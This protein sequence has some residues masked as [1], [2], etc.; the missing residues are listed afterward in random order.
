[1]QKIRDIS[2]PGWFTSILLLIVGFATFGLLAPQLGF[3]WDDWSKTLVNILYGFEGYLDYYAGD[4]PLS[5][6]THVLFVSLIGNNQLYWQIL[7]T[8]LRILSAIGLWWSFKA[9]WPA[10]QRDISLAATL[11]LVLPIF[12][13]QAAAVTF[14]QQWLQAACYFFALGLLIRSLKSKKWWVLL[15]IFS[16]LLNALQLT[17]TEYYFGL[18]LILPLFVGLHFRNQNLEGWSFW[19]N[20]FLHS[21]PYF[22]LSIIYALWRFVWMKLPE[23]DPY[24]MVTLKQ[25]GSQPLQ[26]TLALVKIIA[27]DLLEVI[28][29]SWAPVF[30]LSLSTANQ[31]FTLIS[32]TLSFFVAVSV[33]LFF[34]TQKET[35]E[36]QPEKVQPHWISQ[37][38]L[39]SFA[40]IF[41]GILPAWA[42]G[43]NVVL[44]MH[45]NRY[46]M[47]AMAGIALLVVAVIS[48][49]IQDWQRKVVA[50]SVLIGLASGFHLREM[51]DYRWNWKKQTDF[52]WQ[53]YWRAPKIQEKTAIFFVEEPFPP[54]GLFSTSSAINLLYGTN[55][56]STDLPYWAYAILPRYAQAEEFPA[57]HVIHTTFRSLHFEGNVKNMVLMH[58]NPSHQTCWWLLSAGDQLNPYLSPHEREWA[59]A[60]N[61]D[62]ISDNTSAPLPD[63]ELFGE[64]PTHG[65]CYFYEK[66][67]L[68]VQKEDWAKVADVGDQVQ[69]LGYQ[70]EQSASSNSPREWLPFIL[71]YGMINDLDKAF[72]L[73][74]KSYSVD[75]NYQPMLC[76]VWDEILPVEEED[77]WRAQINHALNCEAAWN[78][79][80]LTLK[81]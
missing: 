69:E 53:L 21:L 78:S 2:L 80:K 41:A 46:A 48:W 23:A 38:K 30:G 37:F 11:Y 60:S 19:K 42:I 14:H 25:L 12:T 39:I 45:A 17:V 50:L 32:W 62:L 76:A 74:Q 8:L 68:A 31:P 58:Y 61:L 71:G 10:R 77:P 13:Q 57:D 29:C 59:A 35:P 20:T 27:L 40:I 66:A 47:P 5:G 49:F 9:L 3:Y 64:E 24:A 6:W 72:A 54:Q 75:P 67:E 52:Y 56:I 73:T 81:P 65:W 43:K 70:P 26:T 44:D 36:I 55:R 16:I 22:L 28:Y 51:N 34:F 79:M 33:M 63:P 18:V 4:R 7:N 1:M 15:T